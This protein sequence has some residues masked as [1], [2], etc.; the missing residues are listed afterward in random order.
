[1]L[2]LKGSANRSFG[3]KISF[4]LILLFCLPLYH[5]LNASPTVKTVTRVPSA[6]AYVDEQN[7]N[8]NFGGF[9]RL[10][11]YY[12]KAFMIFQGKRHA[13]LKFDLSDFPPEVNI[14]SAYLN[15]YAKEVS[16]TLNVAAHYC[17]DDRWNE[18]DLKWNNR[19][20]PQAAYT[21]SRTIGTA[22]R[23]YTWTVTAD[24]ETTVHTPEKILTEILVPDENGDLD[25]TIHF[26]SKE[27]DMY[28]PYLEITYDVITPE[29]DLEPPESQTVGETVRFRGGITP[30]WSG[31]NVIL[32]LITPAGELVNLGPAQTDDEGKFYFDYTLDKE[33][34]WKVKAT[35]E[36]NDF[37]DSSISSEHTIPV[38]VNPIIN[39]LIQNWL[40]VLIIVIM[41]SG[42]A[43]WIHRM[44]QPRWY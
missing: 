10:E 36:S 3:F 43:I 34:Y 33:G 27:A 31:I 16:A 5:S 2:L 13:Y 38:G 26:Y 41:V 29:V 32:T 37:F 8:N 25:A 22:G 23:W 44:R 40:L 6:D 20:Q 12:Y 14:R 28:L 39:F 30:A 15:L 42:I 35:S 4:M 17:N 18:E 1:M 11:V 19:P 24:V 21:D 9:E 7:N